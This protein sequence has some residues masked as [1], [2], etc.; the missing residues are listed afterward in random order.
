MKDPSANVVVLE[1]RPKEAR[2]GGPTP[3]GTLPRVFTVAEGFKHDNAYLGLDGVDEPLEFRTEEF[4]DGS[5]DRIKLGDF[6]A[7]AQATRLQRDTKHIPYSGG[8]FDYRLPN[9]IGS[10]ALA[11]RSA[12]NKF[13]RGTI[14][15]GQYQ[16]DLYKRARELGVEFR[17]DA[18]VL[19]VKGDKEGPVVVTGDGAKIKAKQLVLAS[20]ASTGLHDLVG[21]KTERVVGRKTH[22]IAGIL[23][24]KGGREIHL[25]RNRAPQAS[26]A[27]DLGMVMLE[28]KER[29]GVL[30]EVAPED[31][32]ALSKSPE[33]LSKHFRKVLKERGFDDVEFEVKPQIFKSELQRASRFSTRV[34]GKRKDVDNVFVIGDGARTTHPFMGWG[35]AFAVRDGIVLA[36]Y[37]DKINR[38][39]NNEY[40]GY[41][42]DWWRKS[43]GDG[44]WLMHQAAFHTYNNIHGAVKLKLNQA[45]GFVYIS[46]VD[47]KYERVKVRAS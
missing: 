36:S 42:L 4:L 20:G 43:M 29:T 34:G 12:L 6:E 33:A 41:A 38:E 25:L 15:A 24:R 8:Y 26:Q 9:G 39:P 21:I 11:Q 10:D 30:I 1:A 14:Y 40:K 46:P 17:F 37:L 3:W 22:I 23:R 32:E 19:E 31:V 13:R 7:S 5:R 27:S 47:L 28:M 35:A 2:A 44:T 16:R 18:P 45:N